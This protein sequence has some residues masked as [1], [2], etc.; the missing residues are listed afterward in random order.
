MAHSSVCDEGARE[1]IH[2]D[3]FADCYAL[4]LLHH[5]EEFFRILLI[6]TVHLSTV[7]DR[8]VQEEIGCGGVLS[9]LRTDV[10]AAGY[11]S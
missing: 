10:G 9:D 2:Q 3:L 4:V 1:E 5:F 11:C 6:L 7:P 8:P